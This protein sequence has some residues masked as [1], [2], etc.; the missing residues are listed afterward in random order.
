MDT[1]ISKWIPLQG[2]NNARDLGGMRT[3]DGRR[4][5]PGR[6]IRSGKLTNAADLDWLAAHVGLVIDLRSTKECDDNPDPDIPGVEY[7]HLPIFEMRAS[8]VTRDRES[9]RGMVAMDPDSAKQ[10]MAG[11]YVSFLTN[12]SSLGQYRKFMRLFFQPREK[13]ILWHCSAGKDR[14]GV[15]ALFI[16]ELLGVSR[17]DIVADY[18]ISNK[19]LEEEIREQIEQRGRQQGAPVS[20]A[21]EKVMRCFIGAHEEYPHAVWRTAEEHYGSFDSFIREGLGINDA[22]REAFRQMYLADEKA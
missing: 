21:E 9:D 6:L 12:E 13:A 19:Y 1:V 10:R 2:V 18:M 17:A 20:E 5:A 16:Q 15:G 7:L 4:I 8:G 22:E 11:V 3:K 14:T